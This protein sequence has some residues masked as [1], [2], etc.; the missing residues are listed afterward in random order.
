DLDTTMPKRVDEGVYAID[1]DKLKICV[2]RPVEGVKERPLDF[3]TEG[4]PG[5]R[6]MVFQREKA[7]AGDGTV[8][9]PGFAGIMIRFDQ[10]TGEVSVAGTIE[11]SPARKAGLKKDDVIVKVGTEPATD[12]KTVI[13]LVRQV[14]SGSDLTISIRRGEQNRDITVR[15]GV[16]PFYVLF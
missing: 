3:A 2:G 13:G 11:G 15:V 5:R 4:K 10:D 12:L 6:L 16:V 1:G 14:K 8:G 7:G 9:G